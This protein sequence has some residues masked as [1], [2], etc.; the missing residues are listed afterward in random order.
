[1]LTGK[2][3]NTAWCIFPGDMASPIPISFIALQFF[4]PTEVYCSGILT[5]RAPPG[6]LDGEV[7][8]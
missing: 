3:I 4:K 5:I 2:S 7:E 6:A 1:M 8:F